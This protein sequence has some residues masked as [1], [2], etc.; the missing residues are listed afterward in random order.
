VVFLEIKYK[1]TGSCIVWRIRAPFSATIVAANLVNLACVAEVL[2][3][4]G[5]IGAMGILDYFSD[6]H[7]AIIERRPVYRGIWSTRYCIQGLHCS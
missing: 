7:L 6:N 3:T 1:A 2:V 5:G 4:R